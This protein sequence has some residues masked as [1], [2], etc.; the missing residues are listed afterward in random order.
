MLRIFDID[1]NNEGQLYRITIESECT[2]DEIKRY[3]LQYS[4][5]VRYVKAKASKSKTDIGSR[6]TPVGIIVGCTHSKNKIDT[7]GRNTGT[8]KEERTTIKECQNETH[9]FI[10]IFYSGRWEYIQKLE[11]L[12]EGDIFRIYYGDKLYK[13][14]GF[15]TFE[16]LEEP[17]FRN[18]MHNVRVRGCIL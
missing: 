9:G 12:T 5:D 17:N 18:Y 1:Q 13:H 15:D 8:T 4:N 6:K 14:N 16:C 7:W 10:E 2:V 3:F 11:M